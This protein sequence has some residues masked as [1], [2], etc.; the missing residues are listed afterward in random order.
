M[1]YFLSA[2]SLFFL[3]GCSSSP[4]SKTDLYD[5]TIV[6]PYDTITDGASG[7]F[8]LVEND[9]SSV[10]MRDKATGH[11][12]SIDSSHFIKFAD[13]DT[14]YIDYV[15]EIKKHSMVINL[16]ER[17]RQKFEKL[18][19]EYIM[20]ELGMVLNGELIVA[21]KI[22]SPITG[23]EIALV[24]EKSK[25]RVMCLTRAVLRRVSLERSGLK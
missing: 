15:S 8:L 4:K 10:G 19:T 21:A 3:F 9:S 2:V 17:G 22:L 1:K 11:Y 13:I 14:V 18:T 20:R 7:I 23:S 5:K 24:M 6:C 16:S 12:Y 25:D